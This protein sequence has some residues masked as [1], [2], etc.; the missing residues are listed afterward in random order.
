MAGYTYRTRLQMPIEHIHFVIQKRVANRNY[1]G[2]FFS[3]IEIADR[4][5]AGPNG[6]F[7]GAI[8]VI[9][10]T[11]GNFGE[12]SCQRARQRLPATQDAH[13]FQTVRVMLKNTAPMAGRG[14]HGVH[15]HRT[16]QG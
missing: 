14:L 4:M 10:P 11:T 7:G 12:R 2:S 9:D 6:G 15:L 5:N 8:E 3:E 16:N 13:G 1:W